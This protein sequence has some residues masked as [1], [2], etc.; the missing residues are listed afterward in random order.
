MRGGG[1][2]KATARNRNV[3][4]LSTDLFYCRCTSHSGNRDI[5]SE[6]EAEPLLDDIFAPWYLFLK[7]KAQYFGDG[8]RTSAFPNVNTTLDVVG[9]SG[10]RYL[11]A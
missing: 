5:I 11:D 2:K 9:L 10:C 3:H 8:S 6:A 1:K 7:T 4:N